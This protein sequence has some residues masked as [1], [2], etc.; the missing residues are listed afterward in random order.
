MH[1]IWKLLASH[2]G[3]R[4]VLVVNCIS[5]FK[6]KKKEEKASSL[7]IICSISTLFSKLQLEKTGMLL[8]W[9]ARNIS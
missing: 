7:I 9:R 4:F 2:V 8:C 1:N 6:K 5:V 3:P